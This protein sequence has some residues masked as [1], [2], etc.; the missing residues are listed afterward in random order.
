[1]TP[2]EKAIAILGGTHDGNDLSILELKLCELAANNCLSEKGQVVLDE[3][4]EAVSSGQYHKRDQAWHFGV[5]GLTKAASGYIA[6]KGITIEHYTFQDVEKEHAAAIELGK[7]CQ[8]LEAKG[9]PVCS[10]TATQPEIFSPAPADTPWL[11]AMLH[12]YAFFADSSG[13]ATWCVLSRPGHEA[14][15]IGMEAGHPVLR[16]GR[17]SASCFGT[18][19]LFHELQREGFVSITSRVRS[20]ED[21]VNLFTDIGVTP[22][23][24]DEALSTPMPEEDEAF[25]E[26]TSPSNG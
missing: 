21:L 26:T 9:F 14:V 3:L 16:F 5:V 12:Y 22:Q 4:Y 19:N 7:R 18:G 13:K 15:A 25:F 11:N 24:L 1:M 17:E 6:W 23:Q 10:R 20:Y 2:I 8:M